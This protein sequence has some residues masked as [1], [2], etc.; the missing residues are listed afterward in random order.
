MLTQHL[1]IV[2]IVILTSF[3]TTNHYAQTDSTSYVKD[4]KIYIIE[5][6]DGNV[7][8]GTII[9]QDAKEVLVLTKDRGEISI[10][11]YQVKSIKELEEGQINSKGEYVPNEVFATRYFITTNA[12][13]LEKGENYMLLNW[14]GPE[15]HW[16]VAKNFG[17]GLMTTWVGFPIV[18]TAKYSV[19]L[20]DNAS[21]G[22]GILAGSGTWIIP[23]LYGAL[24]FGVL[25]LGNRRANINFS[26][27]YG[28]IG[29]DGQGG[30][31]ALM[32]VAGMAKI[33]KKLSLVVDSFIVPAVGSIGSGGGLIMPGLR[34][35]IEPKSAFQYGFAMLVVDQE[36]LPFP[37]PMLGWF[38]KF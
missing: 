9:S 18:G 28:Y 22:I 34:Y 31:A 15:V 8:M 25:T 14:F 20:D 37:M 10:P 6:V 21:F 3:I 38:K 4:E 36:L 32:S 12:L 33:G 19:K 5:T 23:G 16:G 1:K 29:F 11:K 30:G 26:G 27:G 2:F 35:Q 13:P 17:L 7:F 24:P